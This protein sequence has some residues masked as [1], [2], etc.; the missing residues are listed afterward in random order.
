[1]KM[2]ASSSGRQRS[3][4]AIFPVVGGLLDAKRD[5]ADSSPKNTN[6]HGCIRFVVEQEEIRHGVGKRRD[7]RCWRIVRI[8]SCICNGY[9][10]AIAGP[11][12]VN[13]IR[14]A[15]YLSSQSLIH[16]YVMWRFH[17]MVLTECDIECTI[18]SR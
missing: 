5:A 17:G 11:A 1:M 13:P 8:E 14:K 18:S 10:P 16:A 12:P 2:K 9:Y 4:Q 15:A 7:Q 6:E 3:F